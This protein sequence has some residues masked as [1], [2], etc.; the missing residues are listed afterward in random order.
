MRTSI[1]LGIQHKHG[2]AVLLYGPEI[3]H[4]AQHEAAKKL[5][6]KPHAEFSKI[7]IWTSDDLREFRFDSPEQAE[8][9]A[10]ARSKAKAESAA[11]PAPTVN[12]KK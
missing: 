7:Q 4:I 11:H 8:A 6:G 10:E 12:I 5:V 3:P 9:K 2:K 1:T